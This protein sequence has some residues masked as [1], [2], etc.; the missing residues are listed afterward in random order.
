ML[1]ELIFFNSLFPLSL[2]KKSIVRKRKS[3]LILALQMSSTVCLQP[4]P[5]VKTC[6]PLKFSDCNCMYLWAKIIKKTIIFTLQNIWQVNS[7]SVYCFFRRHFNLFRSRL[8]FP[9]PDFFTLIKF[10][11]FSPFETF[12]IFFHLSVLGVCETFQELRD[13]CPFTKRDQKTEF[14][15]VWFLTLYLI[16]FSLP[17]IF[18]FSRE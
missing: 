10:F 9:L 5:I 18:P 1:T 11:S 15:Y 2:I 4:L 12:S 3:L 17:S 14:H 16:I 7:C 8:N 6:Y 13:F